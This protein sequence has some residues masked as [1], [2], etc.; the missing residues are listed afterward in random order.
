MDKNILPDK[1]TW[2]T[3]RYS[4]ISYKHI[5]NRRNIRNESFQQLVAER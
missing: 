3:K 2:N 1:Q 4:K 5:N